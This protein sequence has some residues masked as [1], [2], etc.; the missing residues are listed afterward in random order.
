MSYLVEN[1]YFTFGSLV[2]SDF[3]V[4]ITDEGTYNAPAR[5]YSEYAI[6]GRNGTLTIDDGTFEEITHE[7]PGFIA[8]DFSSSIE[9]FRNQIMVPVGY[10]RLTDSYHP[11]EYYLAKYMRG[12]DVEAASRGSAGRFSIAFLRDP[13]R[14]LV[15]GEEAIVLETS[16]TIT[17]PTLFPA[18]PFLRVYGTGSVGI[19]SETIT[20]TAANG[21]T[22]I[23]CETRDAYKGLVSCN[24]NIRLSG[25]DFPTIP[26]GYVGISLSGVS[27]V[28]ITPRWFRL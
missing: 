13:R 24:G 27:K 8:S 5:R 6:P 11:D 19:G 26:A 15:S 17:N 25:S 3:G 18:R 23:D 7:Y 16:R 12:L 14:F 9:A 22:D 2:S 4:W 28:E 20:I 21:Y 10:Q 1:G